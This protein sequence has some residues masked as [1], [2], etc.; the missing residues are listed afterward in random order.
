MAKHPRI[1]KF[2]RC[3]S[4]RLRCCRKN[5]KLLA[6]K[7]PQYMGHE[8][9]SLARKVSVLYAAWS[10]NCKASLKAKPYAWSVFFG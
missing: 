3:S 7:N 4:S 8:T 10:R 1:D 9:L 6:H 5:R 2:F